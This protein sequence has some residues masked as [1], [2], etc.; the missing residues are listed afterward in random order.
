MR[1]SAIWAF[2]LT[3]AACAPQQVGE[4]SYNRGVNAYRAKDYVVAREQW[5]KTLEKGDTSAMNNLGYLLFE[6]LGGPPNLEQAIALWKKAAELGHSE[7]QWHL[8]DAYERGKGVHPSSTEAYAWYRCAMASAQAAPNSDATQAE[9][10][11]DASKSLAKLL[12]KLAPEQFAAAELLAK[13]YVSKYARRAG[14]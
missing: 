10:L 4:S 3:L 9:I 5:S 13:Q 8:G 6:G 14:V 1:I 11:R 12:E 2:S 7:A